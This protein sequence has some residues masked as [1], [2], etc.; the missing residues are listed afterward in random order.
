MDD[1][2][3]DL[4]AVVR[5]C[6]PEPPPPPPTPVFWLEEEVAAA[7]G[8]RGFILDVPAC[9][10][11]LDELCN[12]PFRDGGNPRQFSNQTPALVP[13][14]AYVGTS[15][16]KPLVAVPYQ[17]QF[18]EQPRLAAT[19]RPAPPSQ[20][21]RSKRK[22]NQQ[23]KV[24]CHVPAD[25]V[26]SDLWAWRKYGQKPI[27]GSPYPR[28]YYRCS[29]SK[30]CQA[31]KQVERSRAE[32]AMLLITYTAEHNHPVPTHRNSLSGST[33]QKASQPTSTA[34]PASTPSSVA[35][36]RPAK[37]GDGEEEEPVV[38]EEDD[39]E[40]EMLKVADVEMM[41]EEDD[42]LFL[43]IKVAD[44]GSSTATTAG[45]NKLPASLAFLEED[46]EFFSA[47][48]WLTDNAASLF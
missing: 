46:E 43:G 21:P 1:N 45:V 24:V 19:R 33:R 29:S 15:I 13:K 20:T 4:F 8:K 41:R 30:G 23:K 18:Q 22:K 14:P 34:T 11:E 35:L 39:E 5:G 31:R 26:S 32:P 38:E 40:E 10:V 28:S 47:P 27:K 2:D 25:G 12:L 17:F 44:A 3:W 48:N 16:L 36:S 42:M 6:L 7:A 37:G 9:G